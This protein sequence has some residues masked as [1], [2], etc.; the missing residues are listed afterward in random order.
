MLLVEKLPQPVGLTV[1]AKACARESFRVSHL[2]LPT[3]PGA[4]C[5]LESSAR[6]CMS[7]YE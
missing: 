1:S 5:C 3:A 6:T 4:G 7:L 2:A